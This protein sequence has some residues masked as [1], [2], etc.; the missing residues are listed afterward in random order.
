MPSYVRTI[1]DLVGAR[2]IF[3]PGVR[4]LIP[5]RSSEV[6]LQH[7]TDTHL[8]GLPSGAVEPGESAI[9]ALKREVMEETSVTVMRVEPMGLYSGPTQK[10]VYP[11]GD[12]VQCFAVAFIVREWE[13]CPQADGTEGS[14]VRFFQLGQMPQNL[15][16]IHKETLDDYARYKGTFLVS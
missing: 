16:Q 1:R 12:K 3:V 11:N 9:E 14:D 15:V 5:N 10:F 8:W 2:R 4:A 7:R 13:G 6:L